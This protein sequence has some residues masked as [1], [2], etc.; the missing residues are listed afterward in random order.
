[1]LLK[2]KVG[3]WAIPARNAKQLRAGLGA[4][5]N[6]RYGGVKSVLT[7]NGNAMVMY[8]HDEKSYGG[9]VHTRNWVLAKEWYLDHALVVEVQLRVPP[10]ANNKPEI[11]QLRNDLDIQI[12][13]ARLVTD[14][15][16]QRGQ[17]QPTAGG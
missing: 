7:Y 14:A 11:A 8:N 1:M 4:R 6:H 2:F 15:P 3:S 16:D 5:Y 10:E 13:D 12:G 17:I 9:V